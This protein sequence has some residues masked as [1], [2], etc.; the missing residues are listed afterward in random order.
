MKYEFQLNLIMQLKT[1]VKY[2]SNQIHTHVHHCIINNKI[3]HSHSQHQ[4]T[5]TEYYNTNMTKM[6]F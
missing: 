2:L 5:Q 3:I 4:H 6:S 1:F